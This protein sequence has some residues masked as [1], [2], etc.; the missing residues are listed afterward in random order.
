MLK[1]FEADGNRP[2]DVMG[3]KLGRGYY[4]AING[5]AVLDTIGNFKGKVFMVYGDDDMVIAA[6]HT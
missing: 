6:W 2:Q 5:L 1:R 3:M 4:D